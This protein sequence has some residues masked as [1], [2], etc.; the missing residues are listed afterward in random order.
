MSSGWG[1][2][3][4]GRWRSRWK[5]GSKRRLEG[6]GRARWFWSSDSNIGGGMNSPFMT[7]SIKSKSHNCSDWRDFDLIEMLEHQWR[8]PRHQ[9]A[10]STRSPSSG[11][12]CKTSYSFEVVLVQLRTS[13]SSN[14]AFLAHQFAPSLIPSSR[15]RTARIKRSDSTSVLLVRLRSPSPLLARWWALYWPIGFTELLWI[16]VKLS[17]DEVPYEVYVRENCW[18]DWRAYSWSSDV[19]KSNRVL[20]SEENPDRIMAGCYVWFIII[21]SE[22]EQGWTTLWKTIRQKHRFKEDKA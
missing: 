8:N 15:L 5:F 1:V 17:P 19:S 21:T 11:F 13:I 6:W 10:K 4:F 2:W 16:R 18:K 7:P 9:I 12:F 3:Q 22:P 14:S 20:T